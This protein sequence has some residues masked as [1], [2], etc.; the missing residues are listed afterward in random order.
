MARACSLD[1]G[2]EFVVVTHA[3]SASSKEFQARGR[4]V[5]HRFKALVFNGSCL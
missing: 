3:S 2:A 4:V 5:A 1:T